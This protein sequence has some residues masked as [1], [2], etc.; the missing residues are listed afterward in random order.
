MYVCMDIVKLLAIE[1]IHTCYTVYTTHLTA[2]VGKVNERVG[3]HDPS[4]VGQHILS[5]GRLQ[6]SPS[7]ILSSTQDREIAG[8]G[9]EGGREK[10][11]I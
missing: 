3:I 6:L 8:E 11:V 1:S 5:S 7:Q 2:F 4:V 10:Y 9:G